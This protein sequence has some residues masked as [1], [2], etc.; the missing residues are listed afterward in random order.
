MSEGVEDVVE[1]VMRIFCGEKERKGLLMA[2][3][4]AGGV[5]SRGEG[6]CAVKRK[7]KDLCGRS[8]NNR[9]TER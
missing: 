3:V 1:K 2:M 4:L 5:E 8:D 6:E 7:V 9:S